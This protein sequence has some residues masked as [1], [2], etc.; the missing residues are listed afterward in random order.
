MVTRFTDMGAKITH[1]P[2][3]ATYDFQMTIKCSY[4]DKALS[5]YDIT[6]LKASHPIFNCLNGCVPPQD[7]TNYIV[8]MANGAGRMEIIFP[9]GARNMMFSR[10]N[11]VEFTDAEHLVL[12]IPA[13]T[14]A[15][16]GSIDN[17]QFTTVEISNCQQLN[18]MNACLPESINEN[19]ITLNKIS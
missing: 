14:L 2:F 10:D 18:G 1:D 15:S 3:L 17:P 5:R 19:T 8:I 9:N 6:H 13:N 7:G 11:S 4:S 16:I 12:H